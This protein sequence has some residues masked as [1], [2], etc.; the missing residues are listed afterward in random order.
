MSD[1][2]QR[3]ILLTRAAEQATELG[4]A[5]E[6]AGYDVDNLPA[7]AIEPV[8]A[9]EITATYT[10]EPVPD[11]AIF[12]STNAVRHG[13]AALN[14]DAATRLVAIGR[15]TADALRETGTADVIE[16]PGVRSE[17]LLNVDEFGG[18][19][20]GKRIVIVRGDGGRDV[21]RETLTDRGA[22]VDMIDVYRRALPDI[23]AGDIE[24]ATTALDGGDYAAVI[25]MSRASYANLETLLGRDRLAAATVVTPSYGVLDGRRELGAAER[26]VLADGPDAESL[27]VAL[28]NALS[29]EKAA[30]AD[31][32]ATAAEPETMVAGAD[33]QPD[34]A[35]TPTPPAPAKS[36][37]GSTLA[38]A[39]SVLALGLSGYTFWQLKNTT[40][41]EP[42]TIAA[43]DAAPVD[44]P[45][46]YGDDI[47]A[48]QATL[49]AAASR[50]GEL[51]AGTDQLAAAQTTLARELDELTRQV[52]R[53]QDII[54]S[55][56]GRI[57]NIEQ[58]VAAMQGIAAG[59]RTEWLLAEAEY[60]M[61]LANAQLQLARNAT[62]S[63]YA[64]ELAD[65]R[66]RELGDPAYTP[67]RRALANEMRALAAVNQTDL[68]G[69]ALRLASLADAVDTLPLAND[70]RRQI[71]ALPEIEEAAPA[72]NEG[73]LDRVWRLTKQQIGKG[74]KVRKLDE[75]LTP[76]MSPEA[77]Y[78]LRTN[79]VLKLD[80]ARLALLRGEQA[81]FDASLATATTWI[82]EY[83]AVEDPAVGN[84]LA[85]LAGLATTELD[86][87]VPDI[88]G[89]LA[90]L[91]RT[92]SLAAGPAE[93]D[94]EP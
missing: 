22:D 70:V 49:A 31:E 35:P 67:V 51:K 44:V 61:Q 8:D 43:P 58:S 39:L 90:L 63:A 24:A 83:F 80:S 21:L 42:V 40:P 1:T 26:T 86:T 34:V 37:M 36:G 72:E 75:S 66:V 2:D 69:V 60:Y 59:T 4:A 12:V 73:G 6:A 79:L 64:L 18:D 50:D 13:F 17:D 54:E 25:A 81:A 57:E 46:D 45:P 27:V 33:P 74:F 48:L 84:A 88:S 14:L 15:A 16:N 89:S 56:P 11:F 41:A 65:Q 23:P 28:G 91:R 9:A 87:A 93:P 82:D 68:E 5:L 78:F 62:L 92:Q 53:R 10:A 52:A 76:L 77:S 32:P 20:A 47:A 38:L 55:L 7:L 94:P 85:T 3:R 19:L 29:A 30:T 71:D